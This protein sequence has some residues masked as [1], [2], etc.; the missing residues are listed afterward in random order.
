MALDPRVKSA[1][2][3]GAVA[4]MAFLVLLQGYALYDEPVLTMARGAALGL[5][6]A[7]I[8]AGCAYVLEY[9]IAA[10]VARRQRE[11]TE[12]E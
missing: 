10:W 11:R 6:V 12:G 4:F 9:R 8:A 2:L 7:A 5:V 3:W 1:L